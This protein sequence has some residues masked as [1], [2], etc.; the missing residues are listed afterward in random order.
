M[1]E[2]LNFTNKSTEWLVFSNKEFTITVK[3]WVSKGFPQGYYE[4]AG[5]VDVNHW[6]V[7]LCVSEDSEFFNKPGAIQSA[8]WHGGV[9]YDQVM[10][11]APAFGIKYDWQKEVKYYK[12]GSDYSHYMDHFEEYTAEMGIPSEIRSDVEAL[13]NWLK[14]DI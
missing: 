7:Y 8:P 4:G 6:N 9:T 14:G 2:V 13:Y 12:F 10:T 11:S 3:N 1:K 5:A